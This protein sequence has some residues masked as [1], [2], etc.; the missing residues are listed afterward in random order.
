MAQELEKRECMCLLEIVTSDLIIFVSGGTHFHRNRIKMTRKTYATGRPVI[1]ENFAGD[2]YGRKK[3][4]FGECFLLFQAKVMP[5]S[6]WTESVPSTFSGIF[7]SVTEANYFRR[8]I[9]TGFSKTAQRSTLHGRRS[10]I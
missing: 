1:L 9:S 8:Q 6:E 7:S 2:V 3:A 10:L 4:L 5:Q